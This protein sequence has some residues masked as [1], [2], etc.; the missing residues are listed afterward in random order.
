MPHSVS[1]IDLILLLS[2]WSHIIFVLALAFV[3]TSALVIVLP[4]LF[5]FEVGH[6]SQ[7]ISQ[8]SSSYL[9]AHCAIL[10][11]KQ[12]VERSGRTPRIKGTP[13]LIGRMRKQLYQSCHH[14]YLAQKYCV[15]NLITIHS[16]SEIKQVE[17]T[18]E[19]G[20]SDQP[21]AISL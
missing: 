17:L 5:V 11:S 15:N 12:F 6:L 20:S 7:L 1:Y 8:N 21:Q 10:L 14:R 16:S 4:S 19:K 13:G 2:L 3:L 9:T 18:Q